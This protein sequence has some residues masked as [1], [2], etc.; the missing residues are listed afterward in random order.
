MISKNYFLNQSGKEAFKSFIRAYDSHQLKTIFSLKQLDLQLV[1]KSFGFTQPPAV[2]LSKFNV[3]DPNIDNTPGEFA[4]IYLKFDEIVLP[5]SSSS[6]VDSP[7]TFSLSLPEMTHKFKKPERR[8]GNR[9]YGYF[10]NMNKEKDDKK[11]F[12]HVSDRKQ[13]KTLGDQA[14]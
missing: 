7:Q 2:D 8:P 13:L 11:H 10:L 4:I 3:I 5:K 6:Q 12:K 1:A 14:V 9:G